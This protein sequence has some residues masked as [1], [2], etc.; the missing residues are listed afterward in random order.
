MTIP[1]AMM[2]RISTITHS[3]ILRGNHAF[4]SAGLICEHYT[5]RRLLNTSICKGIH[6]AV[7]ASA[8]IEE[9][10]GNVNQIA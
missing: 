9:A 5:G 2:T 6:R 10:P 7:T 3:K 8:D 4:R 1:T